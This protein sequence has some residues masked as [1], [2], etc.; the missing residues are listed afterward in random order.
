MFLYVFIFE[1]LKSSLSRHHFWTGR[2]AYLVF[3]SQFLTALTRVQDS[4]E[5]SNS[6]NL[7]FDSG[8]FCSRALRK[9][10]TVSTR[11][12]DRESPNT[13]PNEGKHRSIYDL[14]LRKD[15]LDFSQ[16]SI[17]HFNVEPWH[18]ERLWVW[19]GLREW[20]SDPPRPNLNSPSL[21]GPHVH[22][23]GKK[24]TTSECRRG[25]TNRG[26]EEDMFMHDPVLGIEARF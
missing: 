7:S 17:L 4:S 20:T 14:R 19:G 9:A 11:L 6:E 2:P 25:F 26:E 16:G 21:R 13:P 22:Y 8:Y 23:S 3:Q 10:S 12:D 15:L 1:I 24:R 5:L 18:R